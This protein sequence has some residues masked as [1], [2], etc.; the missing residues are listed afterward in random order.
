MNPKNEK[1]QKKI[2]VVVEGNIG[3]GKSTLLKYFENADDIHIVQEPV[4]K[5]SNLGG[6]NLLQLMYHDP[7]KWLFA[8]Q[9]Y[10][11]L[12]FLQNEHQNTE[13][14]I[15]IVERSIHSAKNVFFKSSKM[16]SVHSNVLNEWYEFVSERFSVKVDL[17]IYLR[18]SPMT[19]L[20]RIIRRGRLE[21]GG[22]DL[23]YLE[24]LHKLHD[25]WLL[26]NSSTVVLVLD[27]DLDRDLIINEYH[28]I[29]SEI[30]KIMAK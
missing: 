11:M 16:D 1:F 19:S 9:S 18:A 13:K 15:R 21:E 23:K 24:M 7:E 25:E 2:N 27:A 30:N 5:W 26:K 8:F 12:T 28:R 17:I 3:C 29:R 20:Q 22:I 10:A 6:A 14:R 4:N